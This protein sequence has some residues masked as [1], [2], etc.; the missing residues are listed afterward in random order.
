MN[1]TE[2]YELIVMLS[3]LTNTLF[4]TWLGFTFALI[5][6][7]HIVGPKLNL[8][9]FVLVQS[10]YLLASALAHYN[11]V[12]IEAGHD[13][14]PPPGVFIVITLLLLCILGTVGTV[15]YGVYAYRNRGSLT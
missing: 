10:M 15:L 3:E 9:L 6:A 12:L 1:P 7:W 13:P 8:V 4:Q 5:V 2:Y 11:N 14:F